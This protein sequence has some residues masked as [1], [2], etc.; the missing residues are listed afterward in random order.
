MKRFETLADVGPKDVLTPEIAAR[1]IH[2]KAGYIR[3]RIRERELKAVDRGGWLIR[4]EDFLQW[5]R[6]EDKPLLQQDDACDML[7]AMKALGFGLS[8]D[9]RKGL[10]TYF[11]GEAHH[12]PS[13][14][15]IGKASDIAKRLS[16]IQTG[17]PDKLRAWALVSGDHEARYHRMFARY[18]LH[19]EWFQLSGE[20][21]D[22]IKHINASMCTR[23][24]G[25]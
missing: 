12:I 15:K 11:V 2:R 8:C 18:R 3:A 25:Y 21:I 5:A 20:I 6:H 19:G 10:V 1:L 16:Q 4:G 7:E 22:E 13:T 17:Y 24:G 23:V 9:K 14:I